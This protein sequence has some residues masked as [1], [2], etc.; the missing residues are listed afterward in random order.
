[1]FSSFSG[2]PEQGASCLACDW[3]ID[4][5]KAG[6]MQ[7]HILSCSAT[8]EADRAKVVQA[9]ENK[10]K[11]SSADKQAS[12]T[13]EQTHRQSSSSD[14]TPR[15]NVIGRM[16]ELSLQEAEDGSELTGIYL[17]QQRVSA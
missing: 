7:K 17:A 1:M 8:T 2:D 11:A 10:K 6:R 4:T 5:P 12:T 3:T 16:G 15:V 13:E 14:F 9:R